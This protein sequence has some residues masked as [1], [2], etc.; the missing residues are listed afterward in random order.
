MLRVSCVQASAYLKPVESSLHY[1][2]TGSLLVSASEDPPI[3]QFGGCSRPG[4]SQSLADEKDSGG[5]FDKVHHNSDSRGRP[6]MWGGLRTSGAVYFCHNGFMIPP[7]KPRR[8]GRRWEAVGARQE[9]VDAVDAIG[10]LTP[11]DRR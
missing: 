2:L 6:G 7:V 9:A 11:A 1:V 3:T 10:S 4:P 8:P 5:R